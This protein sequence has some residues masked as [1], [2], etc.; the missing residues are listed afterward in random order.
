MTTE[1]DESPVGHLDLV[2]ERS[3]AKFFSHPREENPP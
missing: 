2:R 1:I 3:N